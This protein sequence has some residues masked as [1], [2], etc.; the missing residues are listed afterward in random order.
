M[1]AEQAGKVHDLADLFRTVHIACQYL[2]TDIAL[3]TSGTSCA[4]RDPEIAKHAEKAI[5]GH[6]LSAARAQNSDSA[7]HIVDA[8][9]RSM[10]S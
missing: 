4:N 2:D 10:T 5:R 6:S 9:P 1:K 8:P 3:C 7:A